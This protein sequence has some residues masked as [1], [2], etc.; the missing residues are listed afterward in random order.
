M[1]DTG[2]KRRSYGAEG[3]HILLPDQSIAVRSGEQRLVPAG[4][5]VRAL[6]KLCNEHID[7]WG[8]SG[9]V[10]RGR[11][12]DVRGSAISDTYTHPIFAF[13]DEL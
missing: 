9:F 13:R 2:T 3:R 12:V 8:C 5:G 7:A 1:D 11:N 10:I 4:A 6:P